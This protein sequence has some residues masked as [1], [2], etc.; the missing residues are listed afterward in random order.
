MPSSRENLI[1]QQNILQNINKLKIYGG[2]FHH[3]VEKHIPLFFSQLFTQQCLIENFISNINFLNVIKSSRPK[4]N[5]NNP[6]SLH[7]VISCEGTSYQHLEEFIQTYFFS[8]NTN[9]QIQESIIE[10]LSDFDNRD[11]NIWTQYFCFHT[12]PSIFGFF[13]IG[14]DFIDFVKKIL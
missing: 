5:A 11:Q 7:S 9:T 12:F 4:M 1:T 14:N 6:F 10:L 8:Q 13:I 2:V 3:Q